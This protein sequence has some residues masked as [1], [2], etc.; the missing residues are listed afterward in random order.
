MGSLPNT[1]GPLSASASR[2]NQFP[3]SDHEI[4][5]ENARH[6]I[7]GIRQVDTKKKKARKKLEGIEKMPKMVGDS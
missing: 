5:K 7:P 2:D 4:F 1:R 6:R 3:V